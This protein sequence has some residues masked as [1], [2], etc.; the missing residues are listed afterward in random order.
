MRAIDCQSGEAVAIAFDRLF[1]QHGAL[2]Q[3]LT[4]LLTIYVALF[5]FNLL[6]GRGRLT[7]DML[8]P[9]MLQLGLALTFATSWVAY[10]SV[11]WNLLVEA[12]DEIASL[13]LNTKGSATEAFALRLDGLFDVLSRSAQLA[14]SANA[15]AP[16]P[17]SP[18]PQ[19]AGTPARP[20][21]LLWLASLMLLLGTVGVLVV[22]RIALAAVMAIGPLFI[23]LVLFRGTRGLLEGWLKAALMLAVTPVLAVLLGGATMVIIDPMIA[24]LVHAGGKVPVGLA[25]SLFLAA[26]VYVAL[27]MLAMRAARLIAG[28]WHFG[29][30]ESVQP[31]IVRLAQASADPATAPTTAQH[32]P[33]LTDERLRSVVQAAGTRD[34]DPTLRLDS[35]TVRAWARPQDSKDSSVNQFNL[36]TS[37]RDPRIRPVTQ[38]SRANTKAPA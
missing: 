19:L 16:S 10:Q 25:S 2:G 24:A 31:V 6:S 17:G 4:V 11:A 26:F 32:E 28:S 12:P 1:G 21:D 30:T 33:S 34:V 37:R 3:A 23:V 22:A 15:V 13:L 14:Q 7:M 5:A 35:A 18:L 20:A 27:M 36:H 38:S 8:T 9:R 29:L